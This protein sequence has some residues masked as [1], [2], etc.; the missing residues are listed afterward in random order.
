VGNSYVPAPTDLTT[1]AVRDLS[2]GELYQTMLTGTGHDPVLPQ[3]VDPGTRWYLVSYVRH[4]QTQKGQPGAAD[5][6]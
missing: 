1:P 5:Q 2:D 4:L 6:E 3:V